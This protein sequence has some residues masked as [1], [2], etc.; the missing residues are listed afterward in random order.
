MITEIFLFNY[1]NLKN[2]IRWVWW[3]KPLRET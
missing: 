2:T 1:I 3:I